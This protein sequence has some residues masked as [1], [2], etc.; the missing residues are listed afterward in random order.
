MAE[1]FLVAVDFLV[2]VFFDPAVV[3]FDEARAAVF[4]VV[5]AVFL[6]AVDFRVVAVVSFAAGFRVAAGFVGAAT[7]GPSAASFLVEAPFPSAGAIT[8]VGRP[9]Q[10]GLV[11]IVHL[12]GFCA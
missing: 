3:F 5:P 6:E 12:A 4:F 2:V 1:V 8:G 10:A 11:P 9:S 7:S